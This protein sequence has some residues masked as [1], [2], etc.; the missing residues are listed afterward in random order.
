MG[1]IILLHLVAETK[2]AR[3]PQPTTPKTTINL[4]PKPKKNN[5]NFPHTKQTMNTLTEEGLNKY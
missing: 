1:G 2:T 3:K 5:P 4:N